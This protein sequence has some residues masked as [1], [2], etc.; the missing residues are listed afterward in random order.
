VISGF[1]FIS[2]IES[3]LRTS[4]AEF[5]YTGIGW[6]DVKKRLYLA[7]QITAVPSIEYCAR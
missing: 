3:D 6:N 5:E 4:M 1:K 7:N 2:N